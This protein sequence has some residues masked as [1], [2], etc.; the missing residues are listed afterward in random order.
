MPALD[1]KEFWGGAVSRTAFAELMT[2]TQLTIIDPHW[3]PGDRLW[4]MLAGAV[5]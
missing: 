5:R 1:L 2:A 4:R 3:G